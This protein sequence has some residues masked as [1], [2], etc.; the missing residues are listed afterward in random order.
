MTAPVMLPP[1]AP[2]PPIPRRIPNLLHLL[3][4]LGIT[5]FTMIGAEGVVALTHRHDIMGALSN[6][7][8]QLVANIACYFVAL[9]LSAFIFP[10]LWRRSFLDGIRW[11]PG[12]VSWQLLVLGLGLGVL[13]QAVSTLLPIPK[14]LPI[15]KIFETPGI[16]WVLAIFGTFVAPL[17]EEIVFRGFLLPGIALA[18]DYIRL[19]KSLDALSGWRAGNTFSRPAIIA[20]SI[21]TSVCFAGIHAPQLGFAWAAILLLIAV[22]LVLCA[23]RLLTG[24]VA[25]STLVHTCYNFSVFFSLFVATG[26][27]RHMDKL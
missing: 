26:G 4:F 22:S 1:Q 27:F 5:L 15:E 8:L 10:P 6:Q 13:S 25:A 19:P 2:P 18:V 12:Q 24:S 14:K 3:L 7:K 20:S 23:V 21:L 16:I 17:F 9:G 11:R